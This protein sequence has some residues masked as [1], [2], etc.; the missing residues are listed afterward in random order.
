[1][2]KDLVV[3]T[4][5]SK[6]LRKVLLASNAITVWKETR[7]RVGA[8]ESFRDFSEP[9]WAGLLFGGTNCQV[10]RSKTFASIRIS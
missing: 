9:K 5:A 2:P 6:P 1:M 7:E 4:R 10:T 8:P 3:L